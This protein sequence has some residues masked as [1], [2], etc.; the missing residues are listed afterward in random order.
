MY[1]EQ[2]IVNKIAMYNDLVFFNHHTEA[3]IVLV[4]LI[5]NSGKTRKIREAY[6]TILNDIQAEREFYGYMGDTN[7]AIRDGIAKKA[8]DILKGTIWYDDLMKDKI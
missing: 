2:E 5:P 1:S 8:M 6:Y 7:A 4:Q 3:A